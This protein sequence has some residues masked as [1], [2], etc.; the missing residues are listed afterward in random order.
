[1]QVWGLLIESLYTYQRKL[2]FDYI[3]LYLYLMWSM[4]I[5]S[6]IYIKYGIDIGL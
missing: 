1:M 6:G 2:L 3:R 4:L 5:L